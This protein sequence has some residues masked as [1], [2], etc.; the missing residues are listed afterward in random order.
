MEKRDINSVERLLRKDEYT[1][2]ELAELLQMQPY[3]L[4]SAIYG[5][6]LKARMI[7][8]DIVSIRRADVLD[9]LRAREG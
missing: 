3:V 1:L 7:G 8:T 4:E 5:G 6:E 2:A 9:W